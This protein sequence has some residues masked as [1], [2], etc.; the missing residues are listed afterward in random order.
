MPRPP[1]SSVNDGIV[2]FPL[3][4]CWNPLTK[5]A[6]LAAEMNKSRI[7]CRISFDVLRK[8][9]R[10]TKDDPMRAVAENRAPIRAAAKRLIESKSF[11]EDGSVVVR[12][13]DLGS[14]V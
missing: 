1:K 4:E 2:T 7:L 14:P 3:L 11:E 5:V 9:F 8:K 13:G 6:T 12:A 10:A